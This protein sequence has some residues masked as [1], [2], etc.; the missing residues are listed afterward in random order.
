MSSAGIIKIVLDELEVKYEQVTMDISK[1]DTRKPEYLKVNPNGKVPTIVHEGQTL[2][3][4]AAITLYLGEVFGV[5]KGLYPRPG[6]Q[7]GN[8]M[9]WTV[10][11]SATLMAESSKLWEAAERKA[12][13][14]VIAEAK[15][16]VE[17]C[18][19]V[20]EGGLQGKDYLLGDNFTVVDAHVQAIVSWVKMLEVPLDGYP[21]ICEWFETCQKRPAIAALVGS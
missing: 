20:L 13:P 15:K 5:E 6:I 8:A 16:G 18:L 10:W 12:K 9:K 17:V 2:W 11:G 19:K 4:S 21:R 14:E 7:R 1:G 3:E